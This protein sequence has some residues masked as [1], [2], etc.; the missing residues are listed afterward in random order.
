MSVVSAGHYLNYY[1]SIE[2]LDI[3]NQWSGGIALEWEVNDQ[4]RQPQ[5]AILTPATNGGTVILRKPEI[6]SP[7]IPLPTRVI[8][9]ANKAPLDYVEETSVTQSE[10]SVHIPFTFRLKD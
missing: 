2:A 3:L 1:P 9:R 8:G 10:I 7:Y 4:T 6:G 5:L